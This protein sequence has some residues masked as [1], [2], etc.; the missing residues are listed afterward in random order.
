MLFRTAASCVILNEKM[1]FSGF[2]IGVFSV[3]LVVVTIH[4][5]SVDCS[6]YISGCL[7]WAY[8]C[9]VL[10]AV[11]VCHKYFI[12]FHVRLYLDCLFGVY[13]SVFMCYVMM[14]GLKYF[15]CLCW[16]LFWIRM[17]DI[18]NVFLISWWVWSIFLMGVGCE[19][20]YLSQWYEFIIVSDRWRA[21]LWALKYQASLISCERR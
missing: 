19:H 15:F 18:L 13:V 1:G 7:L 17:S 2:L 4:D 12:D 20:Y 8:L 3:V 10:C 14:Y 11:Y 16:F 9:Q 5:V 21:S 6:V